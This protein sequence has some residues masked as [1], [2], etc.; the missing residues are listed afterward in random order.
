MVSFSFAPAPFQLG[1]QAPVGRLIDVGDFR[2]PPWGHSGRGKTFGSPHLGGL[3]F[4][5]R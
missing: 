1:L 3:S 5:L 2:P 4:P